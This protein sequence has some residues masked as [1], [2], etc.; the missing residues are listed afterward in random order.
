MILFENHFDV[1]RSESFLRVCM[2]EEGNTNNLQIR[3]G[4]GLMIAMLDYCDTLLV[5]IVIPIGSEQM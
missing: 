4:F 3:F 1:V 2:R 5:T